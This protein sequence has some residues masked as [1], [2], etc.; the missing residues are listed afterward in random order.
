MRTDYMIDG[1]DGEEE[2]CNTKREAI[3]IAQQL[4]NEKNETIPIY[5]WTRPDRYSEPEI[6]EGFR[7]YIEPKEM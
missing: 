4:A 7:L 2:F 5:R 6:D 1:G 3:K